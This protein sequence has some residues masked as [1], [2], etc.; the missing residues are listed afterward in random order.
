MVMAAVSLVREHESLDEDAVRYGLKGNLCLCTG[1]QS[2]VAAVLSAADAT[3]AGQ[4]A[5]TGPRAAGDEDAP[6]HREA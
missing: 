3:R 1:Y 4:A 2:I 5:P 6:G